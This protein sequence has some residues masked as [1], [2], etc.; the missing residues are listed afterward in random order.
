MTLEPTAQ[1]LTELAREFMGA[2]RAHVTQS[3]EAEPEVAVERFISAAT[4]VTA[5]VLMVLPIRVRNKETLILAV[6]SAA[7]RHLANK[8]VRTVK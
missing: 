7:A 4:A 5:G 6:L 2:L 3:A 1:K 8:P